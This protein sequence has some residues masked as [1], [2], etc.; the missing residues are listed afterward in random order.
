MKLENFINDD[1][2]KI[3]IELT[4][5]E[6]DLILS[7]LDKDFEKDDFDGSEKAHVAKMRRILKLRNKLIGYKNKKSWLNYIFVI[8]L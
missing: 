2:K 5:S 3:I 6:L 7:E 8:Q 4:T 1:N